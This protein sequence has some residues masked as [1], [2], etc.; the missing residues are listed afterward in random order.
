VWIGNDDNR[1][2]PGTSGGGL[3]AR[4]W[5]RFMADALDT[6]PA[7]RP[8]RVPLSQT[9]RQDEPA[10]VQAPTP[11]SPT[12]VQPAP[13]PLPVPPADPGAALPPPQPPA[14]KTRPDQ[15]F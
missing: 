1:P 8:A 3:P 5:R 2:L 12:T 11:E 13:A 10:N 9:D 15:G 4:I 7:R 6:R 14:N